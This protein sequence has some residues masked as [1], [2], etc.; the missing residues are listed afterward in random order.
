MSDASPGS[1]ENN[2]CTGK[3]NPF[4]YNAFTNSYIYKCLLLSDSHLW[5][6]SCREGYSR[7]AGRNGLENQPPDCISSVSCGEQQLWTPTA[8]G[9][10]GLCL[11]S[12]VNGGSWP[13]GAK[14]SRQ[15]NDAK[16]GKILWNYV[17]KAV[18]KISL[19]FVN[20]YLHAIFN[21]CFR[22]TDCLLV[23]VKLW[24][25]PYGEFATRSLPSTWPNSSIGADVETSV[26]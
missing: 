12:D 10:R 20:F 18:T 19:F 4:I 1:F 26:A 2:Q 22:W 25:R 17:N 14:T 24:K 13:V 15:R 9:R 23:E 6:C 3:F 11:A 7:V 8:D 16:I 21:L 5:Y